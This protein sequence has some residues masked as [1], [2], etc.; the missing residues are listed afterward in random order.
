[1][2]NYIMII[3]CMLAGKYVDIPV[4]QN[5]CFGIALFWVMA[6]AKELLE[7]EEK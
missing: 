4:W 6:Q 2:K 7:E 5:I 1:M 3:L